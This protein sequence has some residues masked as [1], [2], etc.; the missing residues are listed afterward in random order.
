MNT[1]FKILTILWLILLSTPMNKLS[2][3]KKQ[4]TDRGYKDS[5]V[6][7]KEKT[8][9]DQQKSLLKDHSKEL[10]QLKRAL[11][12]VESK[13]TL[14]QIKYDSLLLKTSLFNQNLNKLSQ[15]LGFKI[16][17]STTATKTQIN[18]IDNSLQKNRLYWIIALL[19]ITLLGS[20]M[21]ILTGK[22]IKSNK[23]DIETQILTT[24]TALEEESLKLDGQLL[25]VL[26]QQIDLTREMGNKSQPEDH[27]LVLK[28]ADRLTAMETNH[29]RMDPNTKGLKQLKS[30][31]KSIKENYLAKGYE[32]VEMLNQEYKEG[33]NVT[34]NFIPSDTIEVGKKI[35]TRVI[36]PQ[37]N[38]DGKMIQS[39]QIEVSIGE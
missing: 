26:Q 13:S 33:M 3:N 7:I 35:I 25:K 36:K 39:A 17:T 16:D 30:A 21:F 38:F 12:D 11:N 5:L 34:A 37:V 8:E 31:V 14:I 29:Y 2:A 19:T 6:Q 27:S 22:R 15:E 4:N 10:I 1:R 28:I 18:K 23:S 20:I 32:I 24:K 9:D